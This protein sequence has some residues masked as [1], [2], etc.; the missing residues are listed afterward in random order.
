MPATAIYLH[1]LSPVQ[2]ALSLARFEE[3]HKWARTQP[4]PALTTLE[5]MG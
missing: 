5:A 4:S 3:L 2:C 1:F